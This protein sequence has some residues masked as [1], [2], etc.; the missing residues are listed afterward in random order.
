MK[1]A[2]MDYEEEQDQE[3]CGWMELTKK[4]RSLNNK[5]QYEKH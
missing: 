5:M 2:R 1:E 4:E 3:S